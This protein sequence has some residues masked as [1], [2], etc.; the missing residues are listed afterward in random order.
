MSGGSWASVEDYLPAG[1]AL[2][3]NENWQYRYSGGELLMMTASGEPS[4][5]YPMD[6]N[7]LAVQNVPAQPCACPVFVPAQAAVCSPLGYGG[8][9]NGSNEDKKISDCITE[10]RKKRGREFWKCFA[11]CIGNKIEDKLIDD[12]LGQLCVKNFCKVFSGIEQCKKGNPC[13]IVNPDPIDCQNCCDI[14]W[15]CCV[16]NIR[17]GWWPPLRGFIEW[18][19]CYADRVSCYNNCD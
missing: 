2:G 11:S 6:S 15:A 3:Y 14:K 7:G 1:N 13:E 10:C 4:A 8:C 16:A 9:S 17:G 18:N 5:Y 12:L 19:Q